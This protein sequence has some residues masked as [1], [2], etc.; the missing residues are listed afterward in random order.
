MKAVFFDVG[1]TL[2]DESRAWAAWADWL[3]VSQLTML[4]RPRGAQRVNARVCKARRA[5]SLAAPVQQRVKARP[6][7]VLH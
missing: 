5:A 4:G 1:E 6:A 7:N 3:G 2:L